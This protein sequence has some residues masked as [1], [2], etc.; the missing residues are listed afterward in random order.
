MAISSALE[1]RILRVPAR[2]WA[3]HGSRSSFVRFLCVLCLS[4]VT[5]AQT[6]GEEPSKA[7][8]RLLALYKS[9]PSDWRVCHQIGLSYMRLEQLDRAREF[10]EKTLALNPSFL[11]AR[12]NLATTLWFLNRKREAEREFRT[13]TRASPDDPVPHLYVGLAEY[14][15]KRF[16]EAMEQFEKAGDL[17]LKNPE[18]LPVVAETYDRAGQPEKAY[19]AYKKAI[20]LDPSAEDG[21]IAL[22]GFAVDHQNNEFALKVTSQ[23]LEKM[24]GSLRLLVLRGLIQALLGKQEDAERTLLDA[25]RSDPKSSL[26]LLAV[27]V[28]QLE[29]GRYQDAAASFRRAADIAPGDFRARYL[30]ATALRRAGDPYRREELIAALRKAGALNPKDAR[31]P[32]MLGQVLMEAGRPGEAVTELEKSLRIDPENPTALYQLGLLYRDQ[33]K[34]ELSRKM[35]REFE[36]VK[37]KKKEEEDEAVQILRIVR[38][39]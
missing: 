24:P 38:E 2:D 30:Y 3:N 5:F 34:K 7:L 36:G 11:P 15:R 39:R 21:Y 29:R 22:A 23:G 17:A 16:L 18:V 9:Q 25:S 1:E 6:Q 13:V 31:P 10:F 33:G 27:G 14:E 20:E 35:L 19:A 8:D 26:P 4:A 37:F 28:S 12:K 32:A